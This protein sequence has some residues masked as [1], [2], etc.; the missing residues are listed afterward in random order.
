MSIIQENT[1]PIFS[2]QLH[3]LGEVNNVALHAEHAVDDDQ[4]CQ[5]SLLPENSLQIVH[6]VMTKFDETAKRKTGTIDD[7]RVI[8]LINDHQVVPAYQ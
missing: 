3:H 1:R 5:T 2:G 7:A 4:L 6:V 8:I